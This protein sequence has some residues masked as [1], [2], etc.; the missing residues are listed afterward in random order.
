[1]CSLYANFLSNYSNYSYLWLQFDSRAELGRMTLI[2]RGLL[3]RALCFS[4]NLYGTANLNSPS[5]QFIAP[6]A[7]PRFFSLAIMQTVHA[8]Q[9]GIASR[10]IPIYSVSANREC[11]RIPSKHW[12]YLHIVQSL[13]MRTY[14]AS[15][16]LLQCESRHQLPRR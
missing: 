3:L 14:S 7:A 5:A 11:A 12:P 15:W 1:M 4:T 10:N 8:P 9:I 16:S 6:C 13:P 2:V